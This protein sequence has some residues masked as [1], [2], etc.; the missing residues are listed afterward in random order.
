MD[1]KSSDLCKHIR[2]E[3]DSLEPWQQTVLVMIYESGKGEASRWFRYWQVL[4]SRVDHILINWSQKELKELQGCSVLNRIG[5]E[6]TDRA[7]AERILPMIKRYPNL[8]GIYAKQFKSPDANAFILE[9]AHSLAGVMMAYAFDV[10]EDSFLLSD[11]DSGDSL[12]EYEDDDEVKTIKG[13]VPLADMLNASGAKHNVSPLMVYIDSML[14][15][16]ARP[17]SAMGNVR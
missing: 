3:L 16:F 4:P 17:V 9:L 14:L 12:Q 10:E 11:S 1:A 8:F 13:M 15:T 6:E 2:S 5:K 7:F